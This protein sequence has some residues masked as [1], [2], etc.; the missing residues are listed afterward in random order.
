MGNRNFARS[1]SVLV[2]AIVAAQARAADWWAYTQQT[3]GKPFPTIHV[4][5]DAGTSWDR[6]GDI[7]AGLTFHV[8]ARGRCAESW[9]LHPDTSLDVYSSQPV[10]AASL[11]INTGNRSYGPG[12]GAGWR[13]HDFK[14]PYK[15]PKSTAGTPVQMCNAWL[16]EESSGAADK[17]QRRRELLASGITRTVERAYTARF[18][19]SCKQD[20][21][22]FDD[23]YADKTAT[24]E[25]SAKVI[26]H[27][28]PDA[29]DVPD[30]PARR[31]KHDDGIHYMDIWANPASSANY[32][33]FCP[34]KITF[35]GEAE[36][37][38]LPG[39]TVNLKYRYVA[40]SGARVIKSDYFT[41]TYDSTARK[42]L[43]SW[44]LDFPLNTGGPQIQAPTNSGEPTVYGGNVVLEFV[45]AVPF[46]ANLQPVQF[47]VTCLKEGVV[48][49]AIAG[50]ADSMAAPARPH[51]VVPA[52]QKPSLD[53]RQVK[54][55]AAPSAAAKPDLTIRS[56][57]LASGSDRVLLVKIANLGTAPSP[58]TQLTMLLPGGKPIRTPVGVIPARGLL[59]V[60]LMSTLALARTRPLRLRIDDPDRIEEANEAN[61][62]YSLTG[63]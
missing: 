41:T 28:N 48:N 24:A 13:A 12:H 62:E 51:D 36:Y 7:E 11:D 54:E 19:L 52:G 57:N 47:K 42:V 29:L 61:N 60:R 27:G 44:G 49:P 38:V 39:R 40:T 18:H 4:Y 50:G 58:A 55:A 9:N 59:E 8:D 53:R 30:P 34:K 17:A 15:A 33:G 45:G 31:V 35:G 22:L 10:T 23:D 26:C 16:N 2:F 32:K 14:G 46:H 63:K 43:H 1:I 21:I 3:P 6:V 25:L 20:N 5:S 56:A 37:K